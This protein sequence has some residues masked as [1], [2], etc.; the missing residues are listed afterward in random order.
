MFASADAMASGA[1]GAFSTT[2]WTGNATANRDITTGVDVSTNGGMIWTKSRNGSYPTGY[3]PYNMWDT[4]NGLLQ[5]WKNYPVIVSSG[6]SSAISFTNTGFTIKSSSAVLNGNGDLYVA[7]SF[8]KK[9]NFFDIVTYTGNGA[10]TKTVS[11]SLGAAPGFIILFDTSD[12]NGPPATYPPYPE[13]IAWHRNFSSGEDLY[14]GT[15]EAANSRGRFPSVTSSSF[16]TNR[17]VSGR[18]YQAFLFTHDPSTSGGIYCG[19]YTGN[20]SA[21]GP[22]VTIGWKPQFLLIKCTNAEGHWIIL[23]SAR[24]MTASGNAVLQESTVAFDPGYLLDAAHL[25]PAE[26]SSVYVDATVSGFDVKSTSSNVNANGKNYIY[27]AVR[28]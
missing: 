24:G 12:F 10:A 14:L 2:L 18:T 4:V 11:H 13:V 22:S 27:M 17:N 1:A 28:A 7:W 23:D 21:T 20:G 26:F 3:L 6:I 25:P 8:R 19:S 5:P 16:T 9:A 15:N